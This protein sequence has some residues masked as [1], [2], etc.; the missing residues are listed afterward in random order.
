MEIHFLSRK[1]KVGQ[2]AQLHTI[3]KMDICGDNDYY[4]IKHMIIGTT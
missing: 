2:I 3:F 4:L 1:P